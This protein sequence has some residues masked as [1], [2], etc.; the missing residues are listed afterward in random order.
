MKSINIYTYSRIQNSTSTEYI[1]TLSG[2]TKKVEVKGQ[3][4]DGIKNLVDLLLKAGAN[5]TDFENFFVSYSIDHIAKEFDLLKIDN[6]NLVLNIELKSDDV[7]RK[8]IEKQLK[9]NQ[10]Y[11]KHIAQDI[12]SYT[13]VTSTEKLYK[14]TKLGLQ[15]VKIEDLLNT[16]QQFG[17]SMESDI[18]SLFRI[19]NFLISPLNTP[20]E[21]LRRE[22]FLTDDQ[23]DKKKQ[24]M[25]RILKDNQT[26]ILGITG[27]AGTGKT[28]LLYDIVRGAAEQGKKCCV[29]HSGILC[30]GHDVLNKKW[31]NVTI[32][33]AKDLNGDGRKCLGQYDCIFVDEAHRIYEKSFEDIIEEAE[34][35]GKVAI[36]SYD[37]EQYLSESEKERDIPSKLR[38]IMGKA[39]EYKLT[40]KIRTSEEISFFTWTMFNLNHQPSGYIDYSNIDVIYANDFQEAFEI[41]ALYKKKGYTF[42]TYTESR[43]HSDSI[44]LYSQQGDYN[45]HHVIGQ[46]FDNV[47]IVM[48]NNFRYDDNGRI[49]GK[50]HPNPDY[51]FYKLLYQE[52]SRAREKLCILVVENYEL[53]INIL[54]I[55]YSMLS[56][57]QYKKK[58]QTEKKIVKKL[59]QKTQK[60]KASIKTFG[61]DDANVISEALDIIKDE[62][63]GVHPR[64]KVIRSELRL[65]TMEQER[66]DEDEICNLVEEYCTF[67][68]ENMLVLEY[69]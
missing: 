46:E 37:F 31:K 30:A 52:I 61:T 56:R 13:Y 62:F 6:N 26:C 10:Y 45:T 21:F 4:F 9:K 69:K 58:G 67:I 7:G 32:I 35:E 59:N 65:L 50:T 41:I 1:N 64:T 23:I 28:L 25:N 19:S 68:E 38:A 14:Y 5:V 15:N 63:D 36:F 43:F 12:R 3:E 8:E 39:D 22:Y 54:N 57:Y 34:Q 11:L 49:Q 48:D 24:I 53:F 29:I 20:D 55:K 47:M 42:I 60:I 27:E 44:D 66:L 40:K 2:R 18:E 16:M 17:E 33:S 51:I